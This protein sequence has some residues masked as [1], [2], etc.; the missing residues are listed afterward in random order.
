MTNL[1]TISR[2]RSFYINPP[3]CP[4]TSHLSP[5]PNRVGADIPAARPFFLSHPDGAHCSL[6]LPWPRSPRPLVFSPAH[7]RKPARLVAPRRPAPSRGPP[8]GASGSPPAPGRSTSHVASLLPRPYMPV[9]TQPLFVFSKLPGPSCTHPRRLLPSPS[10]SDPR[11]VLDGS[12]VGGRA[13][14][15]L[16]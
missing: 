2:A 1:T 14:T 12:A 4:I 15:V 11:S 13:T 16:G 8:P 7:A 6:Y 9:R 10:R 5:D 3:C